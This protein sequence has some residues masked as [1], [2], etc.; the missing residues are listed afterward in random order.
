MAPN[1]Y[2]IDIDKYD[3]VWFDGFTPDG[4]LFKVDAKTRKITGY[5]PPTA[6]LPRRIQA[7]S[8]GIIWFAEFA[9]GKIGRFDPKTE[10]FK[11]YALP[12]PEASPYA[13]GIDKNH[14]V[15]YSSEQM[16]V[17]G[18]IGPE[19]R[20]GARISLRSVRKCDE[21]IHSRFPGKN[22]VWFGTE[23]QGRLLLLG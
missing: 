9:A 13:L 11:E 6:G 14:Y 15:W 22:V 16:D 20:A 4:K 3:N 7:D 21:R 23:Q 12:G 5:Q 17:V 8:D 18:T 10:T 2:G 1:T 19:D